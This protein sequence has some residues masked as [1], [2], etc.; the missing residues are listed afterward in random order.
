MGPIGTYYLTEYVN[1]SGGSTLDAIQGSSY[2]QNAAAAPYQEGPIAVFGDL[3]VVRTTGYEQGLSGGEYTGVPGLTVQ[4]VFDG[5]TYTSAL[6]GGNDFYYDGTT[7]GRVNYSVGFYTG[8]VIATDTSWGGSGTVLFSTGNPEDLGI[9]YDGTNNSLWIMSYYSGQITD[10]SLAG[11]ALSTFNVSASD[12][13]GEYTALA[14]DVDHTLWYEDYGTGT[15]QHFATD[16]TSLGS[17]TYTG[18]GYALGGEIAP[19][20]VPEPGTLLPA[21]MAA[22]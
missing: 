21:A 1:G 14:L 6:G 10:Y 19:S 12:P 7:D 16:G 2:Q 5:T 4:R 17:A 9:T 22:R 13:Y 20:A 18:L 3:G 8:D 11:T 15:I